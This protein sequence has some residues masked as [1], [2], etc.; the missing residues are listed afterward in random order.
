MIDLDK[1]K[2]IEVGDEFSN[3]KELLD[4]LGLKRY[5]G[6]KGKKIIVDML[7]QY[8]SFEHLPSKWGSKKS[9]RIIITEVKI[10]D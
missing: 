4:K 10:K 6:G 3:L 7:N 9:H 5:N 1:L 2:E 8:L